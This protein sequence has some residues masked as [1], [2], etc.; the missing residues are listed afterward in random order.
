ML[1]VGDLLRRRY[2]RMPRYPSRS[3]GNGEGFASRRGRPSDI[4]L[5]HRLR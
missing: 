5:Q 4:R 1:R 3:L 2:P